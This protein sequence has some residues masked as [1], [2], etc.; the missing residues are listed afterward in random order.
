V[1]RG[2][3]GRLPWIGFNVVGTMAP[4]RE[5][6]VTLSKD[7]AASGGS[8][9]LDLHIRRPAE[10]EAALTKARDEILE[11]LHGAGVGATPR[12]W[13]IEDLG[14]AI[15]FAGT[16]RMHASPRFGMLDGWSRMHAVPNVVV[17]D[18][19]AFTTGPEKNPVLTAMAL[20]ARASDRLARD[21]RA[22]YI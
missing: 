4:S 21:L 14:N 13:K 19:S 17:A 16:C 22:G 3:P 9:G 2:T 12:L 18:S 20:S 5:N 10:S 1:L 11:L 7:P 6:G 8:A 15:H